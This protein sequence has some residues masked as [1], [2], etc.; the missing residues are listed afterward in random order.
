MTKKPPAPKVKVEM[1]QRKSGVLVPVDQ[2]DQCRHIEVFKRIQANPQINRYHCPGC[3]DKLLMVILQYALMTQEG[4]EGFKKR[5]IEAA[6]AARRKAETG[7]ILPDEV[8]REQ[9]QQ[10][11][12]R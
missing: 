4:F 10:G 2:V 3:G 11:G 1:G 7:I 12:K 6:K 9:Q 5:Q 8:R